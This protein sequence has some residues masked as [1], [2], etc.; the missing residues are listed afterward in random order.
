VR[1]VGFD[2]GTTNTLISIISRG[3]VINIG[4]EEQ[5]ERPF[6]SVVRYDGEATV[7]G[8]EA[9]R[10]LSVVGL[11][12]HENVV[13]SPKMYL[14]DDSLPVAGV[15]RAPASVAGEVIRYV[16][17]RAL[18]GAQRNLLNEEFGSIA[19]AVAT[20]P[21]TWNGPRRAALRDAFKLAGI[22]VTQFVHEPFAALYG[23]LR[24]AGPDDRQLRSMSRQNLLV[25]DWGGGTLDITLCRVEDG[26]V[27]Q[28]TN[29]GD[30]EV[31]GDRFDEAIALQ[32]IESF[33]GQ[34]GQGTSAR[35]RAGAQAAVLADVERAK[36]DL[37]SSDRGDKTLFVEG[38]FDDGPGDLKYR[39]NRDE[40][41]H[42]TR[43][44]VR[45]GIDKVRSV[46]STAGL[47]ET[48]IAKVLVVGGM[49]AMP[50]I[51]SQLFELFGPERV[52]ISE[53]SGTL[54]AEGAAWVAHDNCRLVLSKPVELQL[55]RSAFYTLVNTTTE[56]GHGWKDRVPL[57]C[58]D[59]TD[60]VAKFLFCTP[61]RICSVPQSSDLRL[62]LGT[63]CL[64]P[65]ATRRRK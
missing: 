3:K 23:R 45:T 36:I 18:A 57:Y 12:V 17:A 10:G 7:V 15:E 52:D 39:L 30:A 16:K 37:S 47:A 21:V 26:R 33:R 9:K 40:L 19:E 41:E 48:Q 51:Q 14:G 1:S 22:E 61:Q 5:S 29:G 42:A 2:F 63:L 44:L 13:K 62:T 24:S 65:S 32:V 49:S 64:A 8:H 60:G 27:A 6:P 4:D 38:V 53:R 50:A 56:M 55:A 28:L 58:T 11:G 46:L 54:V 35:L 59:P 20:I 43:E 25:V 31:G 34:E